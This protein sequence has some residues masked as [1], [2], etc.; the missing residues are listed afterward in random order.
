MS[1]N[2]DDQTRYA[3]F[4][5]RNGRCQHCGTR[6]KWEEF[7]IR[8]RSGGWVLEMHKEADEAEPAERGLALCYKCLDFEGRGR[9]GKVWV[10][11]E[12]S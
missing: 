7:G 2:V 8:G 6:L 12:Q 1:Q 9:T 3:I 10:I 5:K 4:R 11:S